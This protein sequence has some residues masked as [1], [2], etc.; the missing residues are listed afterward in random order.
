MNQT[1]TLL[2]NILNAQSV[3]VEIQTASIIALGD[4]ALAAEQQFKPHLSTTTAIL[5]AAG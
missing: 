3:D 5:V 1:V 2:Q 4:L